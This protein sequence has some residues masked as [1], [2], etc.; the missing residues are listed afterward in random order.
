M[1][2]SNLEIDK[3]SIATKSNLNFAIKSDQV[4]KFVEILVGLEIDFNSNNVLP[5][6][7]LF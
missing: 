1:I 5:L 4:H 7:F 6:V 2:R 3:E